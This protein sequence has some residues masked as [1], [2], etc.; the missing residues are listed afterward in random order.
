MLGTELLAAQS[1][2]LLSSA[3]V[4]QVPHA[5]GTATSVRV[6]HLLGCNAPNQALRV[7]RVSI[8]GSVG[9]GVLNSLGLLSIRHV[10]GYAFTSDP[11]M[12]RLI[13]DNLPFLALF[14]VCMYLCLSTPQGIN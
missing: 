8:L 1:V 2:L 9:V 7:A 5:V 10:W 13:S 6:G 4:A 3:I 12:V 14:Q 11:K